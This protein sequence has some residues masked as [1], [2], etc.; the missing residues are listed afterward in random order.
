MGNVIVQTQPT[1]SSDTAT[2]SAMANI[3]YRFAHWSDGNT[4]N[5]RTLVLTQDTA[6]IAY[7]ALVVHDTTVLHDTTI[8]H[9]TTYVPVHDT[10]YIFIHDTTIVR[11][12]ITVTEYIHDTTYVNHTDTLY[13][14]DT[15]YIHD[16]IYVNQEGINGAKVINAKIYAQSGQI[17]VEG[18]EAMP[19][20]LYDTTGRLLASKQE[21]I[22]IVYLDV[23]VSGTYLVRIGK[24]PAKRVVVIR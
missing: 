10:T 11:D 15:I 14:Y 19:V 22:G 1:C 18:A 23:P 6:L 5:S 13:I 12:T 4:D 20:M 21:H 9:D 7:F 8:V 16:T 3:G 24:L 17:V 2:F